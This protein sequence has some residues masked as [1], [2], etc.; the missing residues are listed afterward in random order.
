[1]SQKTPFLSGIALIIPPPRDP[2]NLSNF[3]TFVFAHK[4]KSVK[5]KLSKYKEQTKNWLKHIAPW[6][7]K[8]HWNYLSKFILLHPVLKTVKVLTCPYFLARLV[9][10]SLTL[11]SLVGDLGV[12]VTV[13]FF[14][15]LLCCPFWF[16]RMSFVPFLVFPLLLAPLWLPPFWL[17][18]FWFA[19]FWLLPCWLLPFWLLPFWLFPFLLMSFS[20]NCVSLNSKD[21]SGP[22]GTELAISERFCQEQI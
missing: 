11:S 4:T 5:I 20:A 22:H 7:Y 17:A 14:P 15:P 6:L 19:P 8:I 9:P 16:G 12:F 1:M 2:R 3:F 18:P 21:S 10:T 13:P